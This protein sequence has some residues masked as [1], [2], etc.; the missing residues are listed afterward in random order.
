MAVPR[1]SQETARGL[2][3][4]GR[5][6]PVYVPRSVQPRRGGVWGWA[7]SGLILALGLAIYTAGHVHTPPSPV[8]APVPRWG[9]LTLTRVALRAARRAG[10]PHPRHGRW[11]ST[12]W[13]DALPLLIGRS[14]GNAE[15]D[16]LVTML[17]HFHEGPTP[18]T[19]PDS[20]SSGSRLVLLVRGFDGH[21]TGI[22]IS[23][24]R[25]ARITRLGVVHPLPLGLHLF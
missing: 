19:L 13:M 12:Q 15:A 20:L 24:R 2:A 17:G 22:L 6:G 25:F 14:S 18:V 7:L 5:S 4:E 3:P 21:V 8:S 23:N 16:Y 10:E 11:V 1:A 9:S